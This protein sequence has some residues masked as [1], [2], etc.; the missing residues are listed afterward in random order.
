MVA[1]SVW[2]RSA[3]LL[4]L[5]CLLLATYSSQP[6]VALQVAG[7][8]SQKVPVLNESNS[9][10][11]RAFGEALAAVIVKVTGEQ[12]WLLDPVVVNA[13]RNAQ[14]Y[15]ER[16]KFS[17]E[18]I[19]SEIVEA[20][21]DDASSSVQ[22]TTANLDASAEISEL[23]AAEVASTPGVF[24]APAEAV[25]APPTEQRFINVD[26]SATLINELLLDAKIPVWDSNRPSVLVWMALQDEV[27]D[28]SLL[29]SETNPEIVKLIRDF[30]DERGLP[31]I[32]PV[33]DFEDRRNVT[34]DT[35]WSL[36]ESVV[37]QAS[38]RYG[39]DSIMSGRLHFTAG[40]DLV[41]VWQFIFQDQTLRFDGYDKELMPYLRAPLDK[42]T[43]QLA[44]YFAIV[45]ETSDFEIVQ[46]RVDGVGTLQA[47]S[48]LMTYVN[49]LGLVESATTVALDGERLDLRLSLLGNPNQLAELIA[50]DRDLLPIQNISLENQLQLH[51]RWTR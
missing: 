26:F 21:A 29:S 18:S 2:R 23:T 28:R 4:G 7:L 33:L 44:S 47:Y 12:R 40:G 3:W 10:R 14:S 34:E 51:Y 9:E 5:L 50:L 6:S 20:R 39:A 45:P 22:G 15:V 35:I 49:A 48:S 32:F 25:T 46:L 8:Y 19:P 1:R 43:T 13:V 36:D 24:P 30:A 38:E 27:G 11:N 16:V 41:G 31:I 37:R 42:I 17:G